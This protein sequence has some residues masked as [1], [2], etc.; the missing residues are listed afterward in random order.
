MTEYNDIPSA[1][2]AL[3]ERL[4]PGA[5]IDVIVHQ[6]QD[7]GTRYRFIPLSGNGNGAVKIKPISELQAKL[8]ESTPKAETPKAATPKPETSKPETPKAETPKAAKAAKPKAETP[9]AAKA[10]KPKAAK[11]KPEISEPKTPKPEI[12]EPEADQ[13]I[14]DA[15]AGGDWQRELRARQLKYAET[16]DKDVS[17]VE[18]EDVDDLPYYDQLDSQ[19]A[20]EPAGNGN[21]DGFPSFVE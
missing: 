14:C 20:Q 7:G 15:E 21:K 9:K 17:G 18:A 3:F 10:A 16:Q 5:G 12:S 1:F 11:P 19:A 8:K 13:P 2:R 4:N 6:L